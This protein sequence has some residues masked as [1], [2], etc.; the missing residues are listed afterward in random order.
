M[1]FQAKLPSHYVFQSHKKRYG[2]ETL[3]KVNQSSTAKSYN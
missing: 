2:H 3:Q 1:A